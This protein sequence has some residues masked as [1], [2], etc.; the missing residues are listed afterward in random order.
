[1]QAEQ[2]ASAKALAHDESFLSQIHRLS[3]QP[4]EACFHCHICTSGCPVANEMDY[5]PDRL[6]HL[7]ALGHRERALTASDIWLCV[8]C[9]LCAARCPNQISVSKIMDAL[10][11]MSLAQGLTSPVPNVLLFHRLYMEIIRRLGRANEA[12]LLALYKVRSRDLT[13]DLLAGIK[14]VLRGKIPLIPRRVKGISRVL[15]IFRAALEA[16]RAMIYGRNAAQKDTI[17][18]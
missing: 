18:S 8:G 11:Q 3:G 13:S 9:E 2:D 7:I 5:G 4:V 15:R 16:D 12:I 17:S 6:L 14:L 1:M 10:R